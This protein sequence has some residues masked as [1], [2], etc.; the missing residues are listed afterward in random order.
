MLP[1]LWPTGGMVNIHG[2]RPLVLST[3]D[4][5]QWLP[6]L[7]PAQAE[8]LA[9]SA[10]LGVEEFNWFKVSTEVNRAGTDGPQ[11]VMPLPALAPRP[12]QDPSA[13]RRT[14]VRPR[15]TPAPRTPPPHPAAAFRA[16]PGRRPRAAA[17]A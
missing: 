8:E 4:V 14:F 13:N 7:S 2:H 5:H 3:A 11:L 16:E 12:D 15:R 1:T 6:A 17:R 9:R 10:A